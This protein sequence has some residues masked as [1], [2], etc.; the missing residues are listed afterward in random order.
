MGFHTHVFVQANHHPPGVA[1]EAVAT[2]A[3]LPAIAACASM[4]PTNSPIV[5]D[6]NECGNGVNLKSTRAKICTQK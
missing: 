6:R 5:L 3:A 4:G 2:L 1:A